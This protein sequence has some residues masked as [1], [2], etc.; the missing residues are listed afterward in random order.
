MKILYVGVFDNNRTST[1][2]SQLISFKKMGQDVVGYNYRQKAQSIGNIARDEH[3]ISEIKN[4]NYDLVV[5]SKCNDVSEKVFAEATKKTKTCLWFMDPLSTYNEEMKNKT[6]LVSYL[7]CDKVNVFEEAKK[8]NK[9]S[10]QVCEGFDEDVDKPHILDKEY[11]VTFIGNIY[12]N[13]LSYINQIKKGVINF[14]GVFGE[15][16]SKIVSKSKINLNFCT[17][18]GASDRVYKILAAKGF[19]ISDD[20]DGRSDHFK[21]GE[22]CV[23]FED[24]KDLNDKIYYYLENKEE[25]ERISLNGYNKVQKFTR[26]N[27][28][29]N[30]IENYGKIK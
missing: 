14:N 16:H 5:F 24:I 26:L 3:L 30:I 18:N 15:D 8:I 2:T 25:R 13:R 22:D 23:I 10:F 21:N 1:N 6:K 7:C 12:G 19:L 29:K 17:N 27:W 11:D 4:N 28:A 9:N 20:W